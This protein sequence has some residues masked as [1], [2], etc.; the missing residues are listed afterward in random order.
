MAGMM[1][2]GSRYVA[3]E[4]DNAAN[5]EVYLFDFDGNLTEER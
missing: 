1:Y 4:R 5:V 2:I 3:G